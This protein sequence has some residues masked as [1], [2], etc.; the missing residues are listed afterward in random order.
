M[1]KRKDIRRFTL[2]AGGTGG[3]LFP[4]VAVLEELT[5]RGYTANLLCDKRAALHLSRQ[6]ITANKRRIVAVSP[7]GTLLA[8][9][10]FVPLFTL[11]FCQALVF[12]IT[13]RPATVL[14]FGG[15]VSAPTALAAWLLR[16][17]VVVHEQNRV[18]GW[19]NRRIAHFAR[20]LALSF[21]NTDGLL[22]EWQKR[23][24]VTGMPVRQEVITAATTPYIPPKDGE[25]FRLLVLGGSQGAEAFDSLLP[26]ALAGLTPAVR[27]RLALTQQTDN[28]ETLQTHYNELNL[29]CELAP[30]FSDIAKRLAACDIVIARAGAGT[31][32]E[33]MTM[34]R[35]AIL[36]PYPHATE[37]HQ[38]HNARAFAET[39][40]GI[41][42]E[43]GASLAEDLSS[44][45]QTWLEN[46]SRIESAAKA[47]RA[48][49]PSAA[50][51]QLADCLESIAESIAQSSSVPA[52][53]ASSNA[54]SREA[55]KTMMQR[56]S[57]DPSTRSTK[58]PI[59]K[60]GWVL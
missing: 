33:L 53:R 56:A 39:G 46:P 57:F 31:V 37:D 3:H 45:L 44:A 27:T 51:E 34:A 16:I 35:A 40:G 17:P 28:T 52:S 32:A 10:R 25:Q 8:K 41:V 5:K 30:Y 13:R 20:H 26:E 22:P 12:F 4:A 15:Y 48:I 54:S 38:R 58:K 50:T 42:L 21:T 29:S 18:L 49:P 47:L 60:Q 23:S 55:Q 36:I 9:L 11:G 19:A 14:V 7:R 1:I 59:R 43:Q 6:K 24:V 2:V